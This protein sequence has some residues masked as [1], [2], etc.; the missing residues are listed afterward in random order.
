MSTI[1]SIAWQRIKGWVILSWKPSCKQC[2]GTT[3]LH[4]TTSYKHKNLG[5]ALKTEYDLMETSDKEGAD[6]DA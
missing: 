4:G 6:D 1:G 2:S 3:K 5:S